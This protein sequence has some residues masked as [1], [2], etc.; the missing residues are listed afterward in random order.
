MEAPPS[1]LS[2]RPKRSAVEGSAVHHPRVESKWKRHPPLCHADRSCRPKRSAVERSA[3]HHPGVESKWKRH[4]LLCH[5]DRS[6]AKWRDLQ[7][8]PRTSRILRGQG[9]GTP[10]LLRQFRVVGIVSSCPSCEVFNRARVG[11]AS[12]PLKSLNASTFVSAP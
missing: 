6:V 10:P 7:G 4:P 1:P 5:P 2:C 12:A 11:C 8:A 3:V 9:K